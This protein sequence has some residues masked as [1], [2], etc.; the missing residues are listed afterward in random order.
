MHYE[1]PVGGVPFYECFREYAAGQQ[2][3]RE[4]VP[5]YD[6]IKDA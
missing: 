3:V 6:V 4:Q 5:K 2:G 1:Q